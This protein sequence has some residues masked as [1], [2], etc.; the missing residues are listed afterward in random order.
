MC[1]KNLI[2]NTKKCYFLNNLYM[3]NKFRYLSI[4][5]SLYINFADLIGEKKV[6]MKMHRT[7][8]IFRRM[9]RQIKIVKPRS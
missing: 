1:M 4:I 5:H 6:K 7:Y 9:G 2:V 3:Y 8:S